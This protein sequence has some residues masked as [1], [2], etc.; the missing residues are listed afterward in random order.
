MTRVIEKYITD[1]FATE[2]EAPL[3]GTWY[4]NL[5]QYN[6]LL[7]ESQSALQLLGIDRKHY[8]FTAYKYIRILI[9]NTITAFRKKLQLLARFQLSGRKYSYHHDYSFQAEITVIITITAFGQKLQLS[10]RLQLS[11]RNRVHYLNDLIYGSNTT[12]KPP[13]VS[14]LLNAENPIKKIPLQYPWQNSGARW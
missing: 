12:C 8:Q 14:V 10:S 6:N 3:A 11:G 2:S 7:S 5:Y 1:L 13:V 4:S 9:I